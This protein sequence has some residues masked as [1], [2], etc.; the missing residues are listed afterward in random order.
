[1]HGV[2][3][4]AAH[5]YTTHLTC[6]KLLRKS[7]L[8]FAAL[9]GAALLL[10]GC[11][12]SPDNNGDQFVSVSAFKSGT[13]FYIQGSPVIRIVSMGQPQDVSPGNGSFNQIG[14]LS[15]ENDRYGSDSAPAETSEE[16][17]Q[18]F[19]GDMADITRGE[20]SCLVN[21]RITNSST[22]EYSIGGQA[23]YTVG[24]NLGYLELYFDEVS[25][26]NNNLEYAALI[27]FMG[28]LT[29]SDLTY[30]TDGDAQDNS[31]T[32]ESNI[33]RVTI[34]SLT[35]S[36]IKFWFNFETNM[37]LI[38]L[39]YVGSTQLKNTATGETFQTA[40]DMKGAWRI[41]HPF[42]RLN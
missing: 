35:G 2:R 26:S 6:M 34:T 10:P 40:V 28:A 25:G 42:L 17:W 38:E 37:C 3:G 23:T 22:N 19:A 11:G 29:R 39:N 41:T 31:S 14:K 1:M 8:L 30:S 21:V 9:T 27:H 36:M 13:G 24:G 5:T 7:L 12:G 18:N 16:A 4:Y 32:S 20:S 33:Q 15:T